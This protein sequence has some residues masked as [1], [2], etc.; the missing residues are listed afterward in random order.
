MDRAFTERPGVR[1]A[2]LLPL[3]WLALVSLPAAAAPD[4]IEV[5]ADGSGDFRTIQAAIDQVPAAGTDWTVIHIARGHYFEKV[6]VPAD[7][8]RIVL[9]GDG[10]DR[11]VLE[12]DQSH[13]DSLGAW[14]ARRVLTNRAD[15]VVIRAL[16][17]RNLA[18]EPGGSG[19]KWDAAFENYGDRVILND[20]LLRADHDTLLMYGPAFGAGPGPSRVYVHDS[21]IQGRGDFV[22]SFSSVFIED[23]VL[24]TIRDPGHFLFQLGVPGLLPSEQAA[25][26]VRKS[27][28]TG[29][30]HDPFRP[31]GVTSLCANARVYLLRNVFEFDLGANRPVAYFHEAAQ[32][33]SSSVQ[34]YGNSQSQSTLSPLVWSSYSLPGPLGT[35]RLDFPVALNDFDES[36]VKGL[37]RSAADRVTPLW[38]FRDWDPRTAE[39]RSACEDGVDNDGDGLTDL[40][41][42]DPGCASLSDF[43]ETAALVPSNWHCALGPELALVVLLLRR[44]RVRRREQREIPPPARRG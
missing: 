2:G 35:P 38:L 37:S 39:P 40:A 42:G 33:L 43:T 17:I 16:T 6:T 22:A 11:T 20:V 44:A 12:F 10:R 19:G 15:D 25:L 7:K 3:A 21:H 27:R 1:L 28:F 36:I 14:V 4:P 41:G 26:V 31:A 8:A 29:Q 24:E 9:V 23:S 5:A 32:P 30:S 13:V 34:H 18:K